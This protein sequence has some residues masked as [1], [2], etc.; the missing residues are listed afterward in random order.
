MIPRA[1]LALVRVYPHPERLLVEASPS[2]PLNSL[3]A[4]IH[5]RGRSM[6]LPASFVA[7]HPGC[8]DRPA[9]MDLACDLAW[10]AQRSPCRLQIWAEGFLLYDQ[11]LT[12]PDMPLSVGLHGVED[13]SLT[14]WIAGFNGQS[15]PAI[16]LYVDGRL[17]EASHQTASTLPAFRFQLPLP[18][19]ALCGRSHRLDI[20]THG[21]T[22]ATTTW[23]ADPRFSASLSD[24]SLLVAFTDR[25]LNPGPVTLTAT[26]ATTGV[27]ISQGHGVLHVP[28]GC[29]DVMITAGAGRQM[30]VAHLYATSAPERLASSRAIARTM[31]TARQ[32][33]LA[34]A[35]DP[36]A[37]QHDRLHRRTAQVHRHLAT[38]GR[39]AGV[40]VIVPV[41]KG[42]L[43][44]QACLAAL[45]ACVAASDAIDEIIVIDDASTDPAMARVLAAHAGPSLIVLRQPDNSGIVAAVTR[46]I[47]AA[48]PGHDVILLNADTIVPVGFAAR[49]KAAAHAAPTIASATPLSN[50]AT[51]LSLPDHAGHNPLTPAEMA[52]LDAMLQARAPNTLEIPTGIGFCLYLRRDAL[53]DVGPLSPEW[54]RGYCEEVDWCLRARNRG[55]SHVAALDTAVFHKGSVSFGTVERA[56]ILA[57]NHARLE[58]IYPEYIPEIRTFLA[59]DPLQTLRSDAFCTLLKAEGRPCLLHVSH[60][61]GGG[62]MVLIAALADRFAA[63][64]GM[65]LICTRFHDPFLDAWAYR[66]EWRER[67]L[68]LHVPTGSIAGFVA[69]LRHLGLPGVAIVVH[70]LVGVGAALRDMLAYGALPYLVYVHD[71]QW[72]CPRVVLVDHTRRHCGEPG[73]AAC[74]RCVRENDIFDFP[75]EEAAIRTDLAGW[76][77]RNGEMLH[78]ARAVIAPSHDAGARIARRFGLANMRVVPHPEPSRAGV[79]T[80]AGDLDAATRIAVVGGVSIQKGRDVLHQLA[81]AIDASQAAMR[82]EVFGDVA[83]AEAFGGIDSIRINGR[84]ARPALAGLLASFDPHF[85]FFPAVWPETWCFALSEIWACGYPAVAFDIGAIAERIGQTGA[86]LVLPFD[87]HPARLLPALARARIVVASLT[88]HRFAIAD[89][90][91]DD[92]ITALFAPQAGQ[93]CADINRR[94]TECDWRR[95]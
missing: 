39:G 78:Q 22:L 91:C 5:L 62:T 86:G 94:Q 50:D 37:M 85:V 7:H 26:L 93:H 27:T 6:R 77:A 65:N 52:G 18:A 72:F 59:T 74:A 55:W 40:S 43:E 92:P 76:I 58:Q 23:R 42:A 66:I 81:A 60:A 90:T 73:P 89:E 15:P 1:E 13:Y 95:P 63:S 45:A 87:P 47:N 21:T 64:G 41:F 69:R 33:G 71:Y 36:A 70:A 20:R 44:T 46:G 14:G 32:K 12:H 56:A 53:D 8:D 88:G 31:L 17:V 28:H 34:P 79:I 84:Y 57:H 25:A 4:V 67:G 51:I 10:F 68:R 30:A 38:H 11:P 48:Q 80:R 54:G 29:D 9:C 49:L 19:A 75:G 2:V 83:D 61:M 16:A 3:K 24:D 35:R 82:I